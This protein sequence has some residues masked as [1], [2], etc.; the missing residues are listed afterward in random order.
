MCLERDTHAW[1]WEVQWVE[2]KSVGPYHTG[3]Q[4]R[5]SRLTSGGGFF[6][7][8]SFFYFYFLFFGVVTI[9]V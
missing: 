8:L 2:E 4:M 1:F 3:S 9:M 5:S 6:V 7:F